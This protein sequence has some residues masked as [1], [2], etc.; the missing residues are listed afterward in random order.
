MPFFLSMLGSEIPLNKSENPGWKM[1]MKARSVL[2]WWSLRRDQ[3]D[4]LPTSWWNMPK[5]NPWTTP[6]HQKRGYSTISLLFTYPYHSHHHS[7]INK[8][9]PYPKINWFGWNPRP[10]EANTSFYLRLQILL[11]LLFNTSHFQILWWWEKK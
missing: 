3:T 6:F 11:L 9:T 2:Y 1:R 10:I 4:H 8:V 5:S 7:R